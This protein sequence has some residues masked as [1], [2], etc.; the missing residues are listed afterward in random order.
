M[1]RKMDHRAKLYLLALAC[2]QCW[3]VATIFGLTGEN[4]C[5]RVENFTVT[6]RERYVEP[7]VIH[8]LAWCLQIPPRCPQ[9]RTEMRERWRMKTEVKFKSVPVCCEGYVMQEVVGNASTADAKC[10]PRCEKCRSGVCVAPN[11]CSCDPGFQGQDCAR[12]CPQGSWGQNCK[13]QCNCQG[14]L[15][16]NPINGDCLCPAGWTGSRCESKC[17]DGQW[18]QSC[19]STCQCE[20]PRTRC[21]HETGECPATTAATS[22]ADNGELLI[23]PYEASG[24]NLAPNAAADEKLLQAGP[25]VLAPDQE[26]N[27]EVIDFDKEASSVP[28][29]VDAEENDSATISSLPDDLLP[30]VTTVQPTARTVGSSDSSSTRI[31]GTIRTATTTQLNPAVTAATNEAAATEG[32]QLSRSKRPLEKQQ[33]PATPPGERFDFDEQQ[34]NF[35]VIVSPHKGDSSSAKSSIPI[36]VAA[37][38]VVGA[39]V[40][41]GLTSVAALMIFHARSRLLKTALSIYGPDKVIDQRQYI[42][43]DATLGSTTT[44]ASSKTLDVNVATL[45]RGTLTRTSPIYGTSV[46]TNA[47]LLTFD[48]RPPEY[49]NGTVTIGIRLSSNIRDLLESHYDRPASCSGTMRNST[50]TLPTTG[51]ATTTTTSLGVGEPPDATEHVYDEIP[52]SSPFFFAKDT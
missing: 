42:E 23:D 43:K 18:G 52:L 20:S 27:A 1:S 28:R 25:A 47:A 14:D 2:C 44:S 39:L 37:M 49:A 8:T 35:R 31:I 15:T 22:N 48:D 38:I 13:N 24:V 41:I 21:H 4:V 11:Q 29:I 45:P 9:K 32:N 17:P 12:E 46:D 51:A 33:Q 3:P 26:Y 40:S 36:D 34:N 6:S 50:A 7:V 10:V 5:H 19:S 16:C 30:A